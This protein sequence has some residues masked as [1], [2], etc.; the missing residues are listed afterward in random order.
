MEHRSDHELIA[1][2]RAGSEDAAS[3]LCSRYWVVAWRAA[4]VLS[5][6]R[7]LADDVAQDGIQRAFGA[8]DRFDDTRAF[9][10]WLKRIAINRA[11]DAQRHRRPLVQLDD[12]AAALHTWAVGA[13]ADRDIGLWAVADAVAS[14]RLEKRMVVVLRFWLDLPLEE[15]AEVLE[16]PVG[17]VASRLS[18]S[19]AEL[20][21]ILEEE[22]EHVA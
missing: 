3:E 1:L 2:A 7:S 19:L 18:R 22:E 13:G 20:R 8:L 21:V 12:D 15:I 6:D 4:F 17:T 10:P 14:L 11:I 16:I 5:G 9:G